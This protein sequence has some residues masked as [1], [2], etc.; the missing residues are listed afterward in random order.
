MT[1]YMVWRLPFGMFIDKFIDN[2]IW[3]KGMVIAEVIVVSLFG[4]LYS[5]GGC[6]VRYL[7]EEVV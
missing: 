3:G 6:M 5:A 4:I 7:H 2:S 1:G